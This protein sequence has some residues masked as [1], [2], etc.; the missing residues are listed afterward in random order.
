MKTP[1]LC[2]CQQCG[3]ACLWISTLCSNCIRK[4]E[5]AQKLEEAREGELV[6]DWKRLDENRPED[7][8]RDHMPLTTEIQKFTP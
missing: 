5:D 6:I 2:K 3:S 7:V 1:P 4:I 8:A